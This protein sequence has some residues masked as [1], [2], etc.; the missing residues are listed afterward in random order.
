MDGFSL[1]NLVKIR[2][3]LKMLSRGSQEAVIS[4][5]QWA[6]AKEQL[7]TVYHNSI[8]LENCLNMVSDFESVYPINYRSD[9]DGFI[10]ESK[11]EDFYS[12]EQGV[13]YVSTL[14][15][16]KGREFDTVYMMLDQVSAFKDEDRRKLYVGMTRAKNALYI[17]Y[18]NDD[19]FNHLDIPG[20]KMIQD[21][22]PY[23]KPKEIVL[24]LTHRDVV[25]DFF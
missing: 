19:L 1:Y 14:H 7:E 20:V 25:L 21:N 23:L 17:H 13:I 16:S 3:F 12:D 8:C 4:E 18:N 22:C 9:L 11:Y 10:K 2:F 24:Q 15:K 6:F 5:H